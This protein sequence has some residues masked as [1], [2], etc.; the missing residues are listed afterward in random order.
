MKSTFVNVLLENAEHDKKIFILSP[1][2]GNDFRPF[3]K[4]YPER[5]LN[6]GI[7][8]QNAICVAAGL[9][10]S[11]FKPYVFSIA[12]FGLMRCYEQIRI[13]ASYMNTNIKIVG[14]GG[15]FAYGP[16]GTTH[17]IIEDFALTKVLPNMMVCSPADPIEARQIFE[18]SLVI[19]S[20]MYIRLARNNDPCIHR[21]DDKITIGK[22]FRL[23][24][25]TGI[26]ICICGTIAKRVCEWLPALETQGISASIT[27]FHTIK[28]LDIQ[29]LDK[30]IS[31]RKDV[32]IIE[33][34]NKIGGLGESILSYLA[35]QGAPNK[36][37]HLA[38][39]DQYSHF[40]G[41][42]NY[43]LEKFGL[44]NVPNIQQLFED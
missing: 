31:S 23:V 4:K 11:G 28:P 6:V 39:P 14:V 17:H 1:D 42:Q 19:D 29:A 43:I 25:G 30:I 7:A 5:F 13:C 38:V 21:K 8:E 44:Y 40:V 12:T 18:Q 33:E 20:P 9:S 15:G 3:I 2:M 10:L 24:E 26:E 16:L 32:L 35:L 37:R 27:V 36:V 34:H 22:A 41:M